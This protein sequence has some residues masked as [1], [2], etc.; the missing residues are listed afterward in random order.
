MPFALGSELVTDTLNFQKHLI[1]NGSGL[2]KNKSWLN[3]LTQ[4]EGMKTWESR[5]NV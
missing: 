1:K 5:K 4:Q 2:T 3:F